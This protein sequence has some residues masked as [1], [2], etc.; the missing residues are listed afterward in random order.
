MD[1]IIED[2]QASDTKARV[3][4]LEALLLELR[5]QA[6]L[7]LLEVT[8]SLT[9]SFTA[10]LLHSFTASFTHSFTASLTYNLLP[11]LPSHAIIHSLTASLTYNMLPHLPSRATT[12]SLTH[13]LI[14]SALTVYATLYSPGRS[15]A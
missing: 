3:R 8:H 4:A 11:H 9:H 5:A 15:S 6:E 2:L 7:R 12:H 10:S 1:A 13:S 14:K